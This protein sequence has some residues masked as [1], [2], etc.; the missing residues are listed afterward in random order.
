MFITTRYGARK[1]LWIYYVH[2][3]RF[4]F[5]YVF[6]ALN[7]KTFISHSDKVNSIKTLI[8]RKEPFDIHFFPALLKNLC[9]AENQHSLFS[10]PVCIV[11]EIIDLLSITSLFLHIYIHTDIWPILNVSW[12]KLSDICIFSL[13]R[14]HI[15]KH[16]LWTIVGK[17][18]RFIHGYLASIGGIGIAGH[19]SVTDFSKHINLS[20]SIFRVNNYFGQKQAPPSAQTPIALIKFRLS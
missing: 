13:V 11:L 20:H 7:A 19:Y 17:D 1:C 4:I 16:L 12:S 5:K 18:Y 8:L 15:F 3:C 14:F 9:H 6:L 2:I 10:N